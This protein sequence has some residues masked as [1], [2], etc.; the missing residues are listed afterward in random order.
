MFIS[1]SKSIICSLIL[2]LFLFSASASADQFQYREQ[3]LNSRAQL[4]QAIKALD[5]ADRVA[6]ENSRYRLKTE[7]VKRDIEGLITVIDGYLNNPLEPTLPS[8]LRDSQT[9]R[10]SQ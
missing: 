10:N 6:D 7:V 8:H 9:R 4:V 2:G 5:R 3:L 1:H